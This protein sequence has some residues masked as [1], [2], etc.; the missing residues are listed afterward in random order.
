MRTAVLEASGGIDNKEIEDF[1]GLEFITCGQ[2][3]IAKVIVRLDFKLIS[4]GVELIGRAEDAR[5]VS[6]LVAKELITR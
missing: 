5:P 2:E 4:L 6:K 3:V 1:R